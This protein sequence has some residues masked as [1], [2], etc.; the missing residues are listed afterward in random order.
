[1]RAGL[2]AAA[3][4]AMAGLLAAS[5]AQAQQKQQRGPLVLK[6]ASYF[7]VGGKIDTKGKGSPIVG[8]MYVEYMIPQRLRSPYPVVMVHGG[9]QTGTN[10]TGTPDGREGWAQYFVRRGYAVYIVD[11][12]ARGRSA[13]WNEYYGAVQSSRLNQV[14]ERFVAPERFPVWPQAKLH[15]QWPGTGKPGDVTFDQFYA[16]QAVSIASF[17]K[18]QEINPPAI[19]ALLEKIGPSILMIHSQSGAFAWPVADKRPDLVKMIVAVEPNGP[20]VREL[21][22]VG[23]PEWFKDGTRDKLSGLGE[24]PLNYDPP[25]SDGERLSFVRQEKADG[26]DLANCW[27]QKEP[28]R[29]LRNLAG[30]PVVVVMSEASYHAPYDHCTVAYLRQAGVPTDFIRLAD[31]GIRGNG[32]MMMLEKNSDDIARVMEEWTARQIAAGRGGRK[33]KGKQ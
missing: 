4:A 27:L 16:A 17:P 29:K 24:V 1:M 23:A 9:N 15:T 26:P 8:H 30:I 25:L 12:V 10:F 31:V 28:A 6:S 32:H 2:R 18:Q 22:M 7:Y 14:E 13:H 5:A 20:P 33:G 19:V 21:Q 11:Q 3:V